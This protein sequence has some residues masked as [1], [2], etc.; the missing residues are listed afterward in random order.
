M[1]RNKHM[2]IRNSAGEFN[3]FERNATGDPVAYSR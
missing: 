2:R 1:E 3:G